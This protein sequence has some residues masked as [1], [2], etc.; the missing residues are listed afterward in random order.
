M[1]IKHISVV[2]PFCVFAPVLTM[3]AW[4]SQAGLPPPVMVPAERKLLETS[5]WPDHLSAVTKPMPW[6]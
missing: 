2:P 3:P 5:A 1:S 4:S 6:R